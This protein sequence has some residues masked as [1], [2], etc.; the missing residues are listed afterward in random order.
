M[1]R[2]SLSKKDP[3]RLQFVKQQPIKF[4]I[5]GIEVE[6][7]GDVYVDTHGKYRVI[8]S[9]DY[10]DLYGALHASIRC[11]DNHKL[12]WKEKFDIK[13]ALFGEEREAIEFYPKCSELVNLAN[14]YHI[15]IIPDG[16]EIAFKTRVK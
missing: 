11:N 8:V 7:L 12:S 14:V 13:N 4:N 9:K 2:R 16:K 10:R 5:T 6:A 1:K 15:Y 3:E